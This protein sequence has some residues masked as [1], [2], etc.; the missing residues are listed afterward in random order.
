MQ[1]LGR[2]EE[3]H[4]AL[5]NTRA[6][7]I[8]N[9]LQDVLVMDLLR[10]IGALVLDADP[11]S[12]SV[13]RALTALR[14]PAVTDLLRSEYEVVRP[15]THMGDVT[16]PPAIRAELDAQWNQRVPFLIDG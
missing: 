13:S 7:H 5:A 8:T 16:M 1:A 4:S 2:H 6:A 14:D 9:M 15:F 11:G 3:L 12:A 10:E